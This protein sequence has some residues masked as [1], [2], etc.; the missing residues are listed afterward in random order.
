MFHSSLDAIEIETVQAFV[1][2]ERH[3]CLS[4]REWQFRLRGYGYS[5]R[6]TETGHIVTKLLGK[7]DLFEICEEDLKAPRPEDA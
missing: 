4:D 7:A 6:K 3:K 1:V 2:A 5:L